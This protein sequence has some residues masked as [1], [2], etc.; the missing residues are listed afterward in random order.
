[1]SL[2]YANKLVA[3]ALQQAGG[4]QTKARQLIINQAMQ[5]TKL[6]QALTRH[7]LK[8]IVAYHVERVASGRANKPQQ[9]PDR[10][11]TVATAAD[12]EFGMEILKAI[13]NSSSAV[14]GMESYASPQKTKRQASQQHIDALRQMADRSKKD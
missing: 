12:D 6:L 1:M 8:G 13:A 3:Q 2:E 9:A 11:Q 14:F 4:N 7:H 5:D 10:P